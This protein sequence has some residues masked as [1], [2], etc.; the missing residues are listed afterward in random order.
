MSKC[1]TSMQ[2]KFRLDSA[3]AQPPELSDTTAIVD[4]NAI[5]DGDSCMRDMS[6]IIGQRLI[7]AG[8]RMAHM[9]GT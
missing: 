6:T 8:R 4:P 1:I 7:N 9:Y 5:C 2:Q 3:T